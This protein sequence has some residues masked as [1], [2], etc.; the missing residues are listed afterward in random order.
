MRLHR[1]LPFRRLTLQSSL[2]P[3]QAA[4]TLAEHVGK[5]AWHRRDPNDCQQTAYRGSVTPTKFKILRNLGHRDGWQPV[6]RGKISPTPD[7][8]SIR[9][10]MRLMIPGYCAV[11]LLWLLT[12]LL[13]IAI[14]ASAVGKGEVVGFLV[15]TV[16][17]VGL[18]LVVRSFW[19]EADRAEAFLVDVLEAR[20]GC[21][22]RE[23]SLRQ[24]SPQS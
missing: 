21:E 3:E 19:A 24:A 18:A 2:T 1:L 5:R 14:V 20:T 15:L 23:Q 10:T 12:A 22:N 4:E 8:T 9:V 13:A 11:V 6:V 7:G 16:Y 17:V